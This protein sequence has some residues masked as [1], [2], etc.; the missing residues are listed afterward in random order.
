MNNSACPVCHGGQ[1]QFLEK[2]RNLSGSTD[3]IC[4]CP[5]CFVLVDISRDE[6]QRDEKES[7]KSFYALDEEEIHNL[8]EL[9]KDLAG[10]VRNILPAGWDSIRNKTWAEFGAGRGVMT[11]AAA[12]L[13]FRH[14]Y[15]IDLN[16]ETFEEVRRYLP[17]PENLSMHHELREISTPIDLFVMWHVLE[18]IFD[19]E[20]LLTEVRERM[21]PGGWFVAQVPQYRREYVCD[22]HFYFYTQP[23]L[24]RLLSRCGFVPARVEFDLGNEFTTIWARVPKGSL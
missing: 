15:G 12:L 8:P 18:H 3:D 4:V 20:A 23:A 7:S 21:A 14:A 19:P 22:T 16:L 11:I 5:A 10:L 24:E 6:S 13:G 1:L 2:K 9:L 17:V